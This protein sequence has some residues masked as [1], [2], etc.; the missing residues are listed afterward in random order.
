MMDL[1]PDKERAM[2]LF[3]DE[4]K[5]DIICDQVRTPVY[6]LISSTCSC[7]QLSPTHHRPIATAIELLCTWLPVATSILICDIVG[8]LSDSCSFRCRQELVAARDP[9]QFYLDKLKARMTMKGSK[10][11]VSLAA[12]TTIQILKRAI[13]P[14]VLVVCSGRLH[15]C[16]LSLGNKSLHSSLFSV[17]SVDRIKSW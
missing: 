13:Q 4:K 15:T 11:G 16:H 1:P 12:D 6:L 3:D 14:A 10:V 2:K 17:W 9:P 7:F 8:Y 5:W